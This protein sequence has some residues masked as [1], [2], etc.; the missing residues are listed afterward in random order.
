MGRKSVVLMLLVRA[1]LCTSIVEAMTTQQCLEQAKINGLYCSSM[2]A[3]TCFT[4]YERCMEFASDCGFQD[5]SMILSICSSLPRQGANLIAYRPTGWTDSVVIKNGSNQVVTSKANA[6]DS[7]YV[8]WAVANESA[9]DV[10][11]YF[12]VAIYVDNSLKT[13]WKVDG[14]QSG[15]Y[16]YI[17][18]YSLGQLSNGQHEITIFIDASNLVTESNE[19]DNIVSRTVDII[20]PDTTPPTGNITYST[21]SPTNGSVVAI[22]ETSEPVTITSSGGSTHVFTSNGTFTFTFK[23]AAGNTG[24][25]VASVDWIDKVP[26]TGS[27]SYVPSSPTN[28]NVT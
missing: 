15:Q 12:Y 3:R 23:D 22:L 28:G 9:Q 1:L 26:P 24:S 10:S 5:S 8:D 21:T 17:Q 25:A 11:S 14:L 27:I 16:T 19:S 4:T 18:N 2:T 13:A 6:S 20:A 7:I